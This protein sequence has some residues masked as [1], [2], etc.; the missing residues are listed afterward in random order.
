MQRLLVILCIFAS[1]LS[2]KTVLAIN[3]GYDI[4]LFPYTYQNQ[5]GKAEGAVI[6]IWRLWAEDSD[7]KLKFSPCKLTDCLLQL[8]RGD[9]DVIAGVLGGVNA[10]DLASGRTIVRVS[11]AICVRDDIRLNSVLDLQSP[12]AVLENERVLTLLN[13]KLP[14]LP[15]ET[16]SSREGFES[17]INQGQLKAFVYEFA[18]P[19]NESY[20]TETPKGYRRFHHLATKEINPVTLTTN[21]ALQ[22]SLLSEV[23]SIRGTDVLAIAEKYNFRIKKNAAPRLSYG[24]LFS[25]LALVAILVFVFVR[26]KQS[27][28]QSKPTNWAEVIASGENETTEFKSSFRWDYHKQSSNKAL[29]KVILK[30]LSAFLNSQGG[31]V[32]I[33]VDDDGTVLGLDN[34]YRT[35]SKKNRDGF[36]LTLTN[37]IN[38]NLGANIHSFVKID[39]VD[40]HGKDVCVIRIRKSDKPVFIA[41]G[42]AE[43]FYVRASASSQ[44]LSISEALRYIQNHWKDT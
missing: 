9:I 23:D 18:D 1:L 19:I 21:T 7:R 30:T 38:K 27:G 32:F 20:K 28:E 8:R 40:I 12:I 37:H 42:G 22:R 24:L 36:L 5:N 25:L 44:P 43:E 16:V 15:V 31:T 13:Q 14:G 10:D 6:D 3:V 4:A 33:G 17:S 39:I 35:L 29:E 11:T 26:R 34:D 41:Q 2:T